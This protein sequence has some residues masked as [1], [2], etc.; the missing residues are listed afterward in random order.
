MFEKIKTGKIDYPEEEWKHI[1]DDAKNL[2]SNLLIV[3]PNKRFN[4]D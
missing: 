3:D 1:S 4:S 2:I